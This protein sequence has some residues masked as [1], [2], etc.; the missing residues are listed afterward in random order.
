MAERLFHS[1]SPATPT[2]CQLSE[3][4]GSPFDAACTN[5]PFRV[6]ARSASHWTTKMSSRTLVSTAVITCCPAHRGAGAD[7]VGLVLALEHAEKLID[8]IARRQLG[9]DGPT[10][11]LREVEHFASANAQSVA[12][13]LR[14][15]DLP[16]LGDNRSHTDRVGIPTGKSRN[17]AFT[18]R[19]APFT[20][21]RGLAAF[22]GFQSTSRR[23]SLPKR[24]L[25]PAEGG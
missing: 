25:R 12:E 17:R 24:S 11:V 13:A 23:C 6:Q 21:T 3:P 14:D 5:L 4:L 22:V 7:R 16:L 15:G 18:W 2:Q 8:C 20:L 9:C 10:V 1:Q 19:R